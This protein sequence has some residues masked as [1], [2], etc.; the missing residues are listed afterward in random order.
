MVS[1][2]PAISV[3]IPT[4][5]RA[6]LVTE[7][8]ASVLAQEMADF[9][10]IV[11]DDGSTDDTVDRVAMVDDERVR[12]VRQSNQGVCSARNAGIAVATSDFITFLD[13]DDIASEGWLCYLVEARR[14]GA[15]L[16]SC[17]QVLVWED[18]RR[19]TQPPR[20]LGP[21]FGH[22]HA[23]FMAGTYAINRGLLESVGSFREGL[24]F[25]ENTDLGLRLGG[26]AMREP[27]PHLWTDEAL[28]TTRRRDDGP[29]PLLR[30]ESALVLLDEDGEHLRRDP[31]L[32]GIY[33]AIA[34]TNAWQLG[35]RSEA[36]RLLGRAL[37]A[38]PRQ[39]KHYRDW[40]ASPSCRDPHRGDHASFRRGVTIPVSASA[41]PHAVGGRLAPQRENLR[42]RTLVHEKFVRPGAG[43]AKSIRAKP[44]AARSSIA[45]WRSSR[46]LL[47][48]TIAP[49]FVSSP[50]ACRMQSER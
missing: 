3:V 26:R 13:S 40:R 34:G 8:I 48:T 9:E 1:P 27:L 11:V 22:L 20:P 5:D 45:P 12:L 46:S 21:A 42:L 7:A 47:S 24:R 4:F 16:A 36:V 19:M 29:S 2:A 33:L 15:D 32:L 39:P 43:P 31:H 10:L 37:Q 28:V 23:Q 25:S 44:E 38:D 14:R 41:F 35:R 6:Q 49:S 18:G 50:E 30:Y 17:G